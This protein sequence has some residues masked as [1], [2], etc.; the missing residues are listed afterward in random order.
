MMTRLHRVN[1]NFKIHHNCNTQLLIQ[2]NQ[3]TRSRSHPNHLALNQLVK[4]L[5]KQHQHQPQRR[6]RRLRT[7]K[8][9]IKMGKKNSTVGN[10]ISIK[11]VFNIDLNKLYRRIPLIPRRPSSSQEANNKK[12]AAKGKS[13]NPDEMSP[14][15]PEDIDEKHIFDSHKQSLAFVNVFVSFR[16]IFE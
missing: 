11:L 14:P 1:I 10:N 12:V 13:K 4:R 7:T 9:M 5:H 8:D 3:L 15:P 16:K 6:A 2:T